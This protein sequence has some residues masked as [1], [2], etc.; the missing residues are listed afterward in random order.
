M[1]NYD[2]VQS[3]PD[4]WVNGNVTFQSPKPRVETGVKESW[5]LTCTGPDGQVK[6]TRQLTV[7]RG[8]RLQVGN[9]C[10]RGK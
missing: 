8:Q 3:P 6:G 2:Q 5:T 4:D 1:V 7:D 10:V 9:P